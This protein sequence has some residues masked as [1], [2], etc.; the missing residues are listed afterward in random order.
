MDGGWGTHQ[1]TMRCAHADRDRC[2]DVLKAAWAEGRL[3]DDEY[4]QRLELALSAET[5]GQLTVLVHDLPVGPVPS[6]VHPPAAVPVNPYAFV[7]PHAY[8]P[9]MVPRPM[10]Q[11]TN[12]LAVTSL[13][14][15]IVT[16]VAVWPATA[17][18]TKSY[19]V[20]PYP[21][22]FAGVAVVT[23]HVALHRS[24]HRPYPF[25]GGAGPAVA[26]LTLGWIQIALA[27]LAQLGG[28]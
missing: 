17:L 14:L 18:L 6:A 19:P 3:R 4:R 7:A 16:L 27:L 28:N 23:G 25:N 11:Q 22:V 5:Y 24:R 26:G 10:P 1:D 13:V 2:A 20:N 15:G 12:G 21:F 8:V 9:P